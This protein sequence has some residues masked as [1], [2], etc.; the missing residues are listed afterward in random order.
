[1]Y[2]YD[3]VGDQVRLLGLPFPTEAHALREYVIEKLASLPQAESWLRTF[4]GGNPLEFQ[5]FLAK[6]RR[7]GE[8]TDDM[9]VMTFVSHSFFMKP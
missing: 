1:M 7:K 8:W 2:R 3:A 6:H 4:F 5:D 9:G